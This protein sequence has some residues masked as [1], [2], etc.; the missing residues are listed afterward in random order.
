MNLARASGLM[1]LEAGTSTA[2]KCA[3]P[4]ASTRGPVESSGAASTPGGGSCS[5]SASN[6]PRRQWTRDEPVTVRT[7]FLRRK[8]RDYTVGRH[9]RRVVAGQVKVALVSGGRSRSQQSDRVLEPQQR[10]GLIQRCVVA[11]IDR[12]DVQGDRI[13]HLGVGRKARAIEL[14]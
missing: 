7:G 4:L 13:E 1:N 14:A 12:V 5:A 8:C 6:N 2:G 9:V 10:Q 3:T 11:V